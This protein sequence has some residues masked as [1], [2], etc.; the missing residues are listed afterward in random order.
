MP[1]FWL[2]TGVPSAMINLAIHLAC[3]GA[4]YLWLQ[5][6]L[7]GCSPQQ[8][9]FLALIALMFAV[10]PI[11][12]S[13]VLS[14]RGRLDLTIALLVLCTA[15]VW[16]SPYF[17]RRSLGW[18]VLAIAVYVA[19]TSRPIMNDV[20]QSGTGVADPLGF[21]AATGHSFFSCCMALVV[22]R[23]SWVCV[24]DLC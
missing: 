14:P 2:E 4:I 11:S 12:A 6:R 21:V 15:L 19:W 10:H 3:S 22:H 23:R 20:T 18:V 24:H 17:W 8:R 5:R 13:A 16:Q 9:I 7:P 1:E